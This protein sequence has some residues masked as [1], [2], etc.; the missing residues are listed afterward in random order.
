VNAEFY[1]LTSKFNTVEGI[2]FIRLF[3][4]ENLVADSYSNAIDIR[5]KMLHIRV[6]TRKNAGMSR[7]RYPAGE[8][9]FLK[10]LRADWLCGPPSLLSNGY[11][12]LFSSKIKRPGRDGGHSP[13]S[14]SAVKNAWSYT[15]T[16]L[17]VFKARCLMKL[18]GE[19]YFGSST[20]F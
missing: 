11:Q 8:Q 13:L 20:D 16:P 7:V 18:Q 4:K 10:S 17:H 14:S 1:F 6:S 3:N 5:L 9:I 12:G 15:S 2:Y 19:V